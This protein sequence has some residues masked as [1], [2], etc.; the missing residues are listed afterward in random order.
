MT[1]ADILAALQADPA[2]A[3]QVARGLRGL[4][5]AGPWAPAADEM[6]RRPWIGV[7]RAIVA[8][9]HHIP[10]GLVLGRAWAWICHDRESWGL[11]ETEAAAKAAA[12]AALVAAGWTLA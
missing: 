2:M 12:D 7:S 4:H 3:A 6:W 11:E 9:V 10:A 5:L 8:Q 1:A